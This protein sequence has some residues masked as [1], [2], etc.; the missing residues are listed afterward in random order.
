[1]GLI[2][3]LILA[4]VPSALS[5]QHGEQRAVALSEGN[6]LS[7]LVATAS[8]LFVG[9]AA[10]QFG[11]W[12]FA[13]LI[14]ACVPLI[15][16]LALRGIK[17]PA[18]AAPRVGKQGSLPGVYWFYWVSLMLAV[19]V[20]FCM[21]FWGAGYLEVVS[22]LAKASA[23]Q[24]VSLF[25]GAMIVGRWSGSR[26]VQRYPVRRLVNLSL[27]IAGLGFL[28]FWF[29]GQLVI[30]L[31]GLFIT[32]LGVAGLYPFLLSMAIA[33]AGE[34]AIQ[35]SARATLASGTAIFFLPLALGRLADFAGIW[36]AY[37][38]VAVL[39]A[40]TALVFGLT[41]PRVAGGQEPDP[42]PLP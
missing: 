31:A 42:H 41:R 18:E 39:I 15:L 16:R 33:S 32:G 28:L 36:W 4:V 27:A 11:E 38:I 35:A 20:E 17:A 2:G 1:M 34:Q 29:G 23:A 9:W 5:D 12:R 7:S 40:G 22:G 6:T 19:S 3:T 37:G 26:L 8:A 24:A 25:L 30:Q 21:I 13:L 14:P 10:A